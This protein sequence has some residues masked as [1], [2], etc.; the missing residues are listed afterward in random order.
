VV[1]KDG[2]ETEESLKEHFS[3]FGEVADVTIL[4]NR[5]TNTPKGFAYI[6]FTK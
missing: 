3:Q 4:R 2:S 6:K 5:D 1:P